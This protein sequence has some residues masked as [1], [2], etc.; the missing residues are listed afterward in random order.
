[1]LKTARAVSLL[2]VACSLLVAPEARAQE[3]SKSPVLAAALE[4]AIPTFG[5]AYAGDWSR[6]IPLALVRVVGVGLVIEQQWCLCIFEEP[7]PCEGR[8][9]VGVAMAIGGAVWAA[10]DAASTARRQNERR[11]FPPR[12]PTVLPT[13]GAAGS[14]LSVHIPFTW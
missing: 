3:E 1:M 11:G 5:Y 7:P 6:G 10:I 8:C 13:F 9:I 14:G 2:S 4:V 12:G